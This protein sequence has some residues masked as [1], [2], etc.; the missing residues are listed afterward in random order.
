MS[1][2]KNRIKE[3]RLKRKLSQKELA[4]QVGLSNQSISSYESGKRI[5]KIEAWSKLANFFNVSIPYIKGETFKREDVI[6]VLSYEYTNCSMGGYD[7]LDKE[8]AYSILEVYKLVDII[9]DYLI[10]HHQSLPLQKFS[11]DDLKKCTSDVK[12]FWIR[13]FDFVFKSSRMKSIMKYGGASVIEILTSLKEIIYGQYLKDS[14]TAVSKNFD[15]LVEDDLSKFVSDK[16]ELMRFSSKKEI[17]DT[18]NNLIS[19]LKCF[20]SSIDS[21]PANKLKPI[22]IDTTKNIDTTK[23]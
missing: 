22:R 4:E 17:R 6:K 9:N 14:E 18:V 1:T 3:L 11:S 16:N 2:V 10:Y 20:E 7:F 15:R 8:T 13:N 21:L 19:Q 23:K 12:I 5:P